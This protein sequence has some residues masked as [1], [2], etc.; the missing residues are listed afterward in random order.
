MLLVRG[1]HKKLR[2]FNDVN[3]LCQL[4]EGGAISSVR[5]QLFV[6]KSCGN[7]EILELARA[8]VPAAPILYSWRLY[9]SSNV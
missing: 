6:K 5:A 1:D 9:A 2:E 3:S 4:S 7:K 8:V